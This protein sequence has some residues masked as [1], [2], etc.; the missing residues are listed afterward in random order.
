VIGARFC[1][2]LP[3]NQPPPVEALPDEDTETR[4]IAIP[5]RT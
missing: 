4:T 2:T 5:D 3:A 1:F